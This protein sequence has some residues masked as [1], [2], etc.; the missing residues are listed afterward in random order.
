MKRID[1]QTRRGAHLVEC[2]RGAVMVA[3]IFMA[4]FLVA[5]L[6]MVIGLG[7][8]LTMKEGMQDAADAAAYSSAIFNARGMN[9]I[10]FINLLMAALVSVL[11]AIRVAQS[12]MTLAAGI[13]TGMAFAS[14]G[15]TG[16]LAA[17]ATY[18]AIQLNNT[19]NNAKKV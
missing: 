16:P 4:L 7:R 12:V 11:I 13:L 9:L 5:V 8:T 1:G 10:V 18:Q 19:Y 17:E 14:M 2:D 6:Y 15:G 3:T